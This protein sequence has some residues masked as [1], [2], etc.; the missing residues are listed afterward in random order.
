MFAYIHTYR[1]MFSNRHTHS[2]TFIVILHSILYVCFTKFHIPPSPL[3]ASQ[4]ATLAPRATALA[5]SRRSCTAFCVF[6]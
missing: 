3:S 4:A 2:Y 6:F 1:N 5:S